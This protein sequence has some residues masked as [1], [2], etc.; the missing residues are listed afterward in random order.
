MH[1]CETL[2][3]Q[4]F[5]SLR[6]VQLSRR[7]FDENAKCVQG[8]EENAHFSGWRRCIEKCSIQFQGVIMLMV[9]KVFKMDLLIHPVPNDIGYSQAKPSFLGVASTVLSDFEKMYIKIPFEVTII[10]ILTG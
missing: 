10:S 1:T 7:H 5:P 3:R 9:N 8:L 4:I 6:N 2:Q